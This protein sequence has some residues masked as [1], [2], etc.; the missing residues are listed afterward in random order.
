MNNSANTSSHHIRSSQ[1]RPGD[2]QQNFTNAGSASLSPTYAFPPTL[3]PGRGDTRQMHA[4]TRGTFTT[5]SQPQS[6]LHMDSS[7]SNTPDSYLSPS[8]SPHPS[9]EGEARKM[10]RRS[11]EIRQNHSQ[12]VH[13]PHRSA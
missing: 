9:E 4:A 11:E 1:A 6:F 8:M 3:N 2:D 13:K 10:R 7:G 5:S 12:W